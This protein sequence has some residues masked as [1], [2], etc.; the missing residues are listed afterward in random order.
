MKLFNLVCA[1]LIAQLLSGNLTDTY[2]ISGQVT[3]AATGEPIIFGS[4]VL[5]KEGVM[6][7]G[8][9]TDFDGNYSFSD[10]EPD[11]YDLE[12]S[13]IGYSNK[14]VSG[15][16]A[17]K[18]QNTIVD[19]TLDPSEI[20]MEHGIISYK[21]PNMPTDKT[22]R[23]EFNS[24][25]RKSTADA[26]ESPPSVV[27]EY[28]IA[29]EIFIVGNRPKRRAR[30]ALESKAYIGG[31]RVTNKKIKSEDK[32]YSEEETTNFDIENREHYSKPVEN[33]FVSPVIE[34][35]STFS[36]DV[37]KASYS[38]V[39]RFLNSGRLPPA[40][41][42][43]VEEMVNYFHYNYQQPIGPHPLAI[44]SNYTDCPWNHQHKLLHLSVK[45]KEVATDNLPA[46]N[47]VF[48][49]DVSG[50]MRD[51]NKLPLVKESFKLLLDKLRPQDRVAIVTYAGH[52]GVALPSTPASDKA[53]ILA[54][55]DNLKSRGGT[56]GAQG[57]L[58][59]YEIATQN[60]I[61]DGNNRVILATDGDFN[62][63][64]SNTSDLEKLIEEKRKSG[65][66]LSVMGYGTGNY[67]D[68]K[69]QSLS[70]KG[71]GNH[72]YIDNLSEAKK[73]LV[74]EFG[75]TL[76]TIAKDVKIQ[77][78]FNTAY[79]QSYR[80]LGYENR[81]LAREDFNDDKKDAGEVGAGHTVTAIYEI[82][83]M[84]TDSEFSV[85]VSENILEESRSAKQGSTNG[86]LGYIK[87]RYKNPDEE[88]SIKFEGSI[89]S[90]VS[91]MSNLDEDVQFSI[92]VAEFGLN[93]GQSSYLKSK[94]LADCIDRAINSQGIDKNGYRGEFLTLAQT[95]HKSGL[96]K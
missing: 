35:H 72:A 60:Y 53:T 39:R 83:P 67:Q 66:F 95:V 15:I 17:G 84:G 68:H 16:V 38:N 73:V 34:S 62:I 19:I 94:N 14:R 77:I 18:I 45:A 36:L 23:K 80:L 58:T 81:M 74:N 29:D 48:L 41:A 6:I 57:I 50:S 37:D 93:I 32:L 20:L 8:I 55:L 64:I 89:S 25:K 49:I 40:D 12:V 47:L 44:T 31:P 1:L 33:Q 54:S 85:D 75:G 52:S 3:D 90:T 92:A 70:S 91:P 5:Y 10:L 4:V 71:N 86:Y 22:Q 46:S 2:Y 56:A 7:C 76:F 82:I 30:K 87:C 59:A 65:V 11:I 43:R 28:E 79:V 24:E 69:M 9:E 13:F 63:G 26:I 21:A 27:V 88:K 96:I 61:E 78:E 51:Y 42:V